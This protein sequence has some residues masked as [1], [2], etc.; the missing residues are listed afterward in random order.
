MVDLINVHFE[1]FN[2]GIDIMRDLIISLVFALGIIQSPAAHAATIAVGASYDCEISSGGNILHKHGGTSVLSFSREKK[3]VQSSIKRYTARPVRYKKQIKDLKATLAAMKYCEKGKGKY[4]PDSAANPTPTPIASGA[5]VANHYSIAPYLDIPQSVKDAVISKY[6]IFYGHTSHGSQ[7]IS[8]LQVL[9][10]QS[11]PPV[12]GIFHEPGGDLGHSGDT[13]WA[14]ATRGWLRDHPDFNMVMWSW[15]GGVSDN[16]ASGIDTYLSTMNKLESDFPDVRF[17]YMTGHLDGSGESGNLREMNRR[18]RSYA[19]EHG[20][21]LFDFEDIESYDPSGNYYP[22]AS[23]ACEWCTSWCGSHSCPASCS[24]SDCAHSQ[25]F[26]CYQKAKAWWW[27]MAK[28]N[29]WGG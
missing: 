26:N 18:I 11:N 16:T 27:M 9:A 19:V 12:L 1:V 14:T 6:K 17:I 4:K 10:A 29:G 8:G 25:C 13:A 20:K 21:T 5:I 15:C 2:V 7:I 28:I 3:R 24:I 23:D 22:N